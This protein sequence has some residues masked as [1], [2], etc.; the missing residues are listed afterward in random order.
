MIESFVRRAAKW[1]INPMESVRRTDR[2]ICFLGAWAARALS[3]LAFALI[4][5]SASQSP[6]AVKSNTE[7]TFE[8]RAAAE[9]ASRFVYR[10]LEIASL[11]VIFTA[12]VGAAYWAASRRKP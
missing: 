12:G 2:R 7:V 10:R 9:K 4:I 11:V 5:S 3:V 8:E 1:Y 6:A